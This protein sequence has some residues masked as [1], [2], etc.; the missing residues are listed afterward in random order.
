MTPETTEPTLEPLVM[1]T[2]AKILTGLTHGRRETPTNL[3]AQLKDTSQNYTA[4]RLRKL[5]LR[6]Y[7]HSPGPADRSGMYEITTWGRYATAHIDRH[8][9]QY[10]ELFHR[11]V[12]RAC[13]SQ[14]TPEH[15]YP[16]NIPE[17]DRE[18]QPA[19]DPCAETDTTLLQLY[20][21]VYDALKTLSDID[22]VTIPTDFR[23]RLPPTDDGNM[24]SAGDAADSLYTLYFYGL[25][26]RREGMEA[27]SI[28]DAGRQLVNQNPDPS[29][30]QHGVARAELLPDT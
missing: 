23:E 6:G 28:T 3:A 27:Y 5:E 17:E 8:E 20:R 2:D 4:N 22:G 30:L 9:R 21:H 14:P 13:G 1:P 26:D 11:L 24:A 12:T 16:D 7:T 18:T 10:D 25:A 19:P 15:A 29:V